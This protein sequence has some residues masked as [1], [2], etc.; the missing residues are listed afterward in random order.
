MKSSTHYKCA[1]LKVREW[2][3]GSQSQWVASE[4]RMNWSFK[5]IYAE[6]EIDWKSDV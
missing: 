3:L 1:K 6:R 5:N 2:K 4:F